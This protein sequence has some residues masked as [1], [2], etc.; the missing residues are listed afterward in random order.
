L[1]VAIL[2]SYPAPI[3]TPIVN[4][5]REFIKSLPSRG[6][7]AERLVAGP[8]KQITLQRDARSYPEFE[9]RNLASNGNVWTGNGDETKAHFPPLKTF[10]PEDYPSEK[11]CSFA[12]WQV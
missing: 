11:K 4:N 1:N 3:T 5:Y 10:K 7:T 8:S 6:A 12:I 2:T 9:I